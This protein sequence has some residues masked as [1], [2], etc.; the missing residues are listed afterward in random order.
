MSPLFPKFLN[1]AVPYRHLLCDGRLLLVTK[2]VLYNGLME[3]TQDLRGCVSFIH[4]VL[5][6]VPTQDTITD[7]NTFLIKSF[8]AWSWSK[9]QNNTHPHRNLKLLKGSS[10]ADVE[11]VVDHLVGNNLSDSRAGEWRVSDKERPLCGWHMTFELPRRF[12]WWCA[13]RSPCRRWVEQ[14]S[15]ERWWLSEGLPQT[16]SPAQIYSVPT[17]ITTKITSSNAINLWFTT[18]QSNSAT[19]VF[20]LM[21]TNHTRRP[22]NHK[23]AAPSP[24]IR[25][26]NWWVIKG[27]RPQLRYWQTIDKTWAG[28]QDRCVFHMRQKNRYS[29]Q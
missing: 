4:H 16:P 5:S 6:K 23:M 13:L 26:C 18:V 27:K 14:H 24:F 17:Q 7:G 2:V 19:T 1:T 15:G 29:N 12:R 8:I 3:L 22:Y 10:E 9:T 25:D 11:Q 28:L 21:M 20:R